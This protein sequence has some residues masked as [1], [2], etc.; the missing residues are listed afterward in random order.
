MPGYLNTSLQ[1]TPKM[2]KKFT[3]EFMK[4]NMA[5][6]C[7]NQSAQRRMRLHFHSHTLSRIRTYVKKN[8]WPELS[9]LKNHR[10]C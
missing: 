2:Q 8:Y 4:T 10:F 9:A 6:S 7:K 1:Q 5:K 3:N